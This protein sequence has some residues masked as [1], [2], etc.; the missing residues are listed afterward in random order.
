MKLTARAVAALMLPEGK[1]DAIY[2]DDDMP[3]FGY[4]LRKS[5]D[6]VARSWVTQYRHGGA[7][8]RITLKEILSAE[9]ARGEAKR[10]L[11][12]AALGQDP[13]TEKKRQASADR[14]TFSALVEQYLAAKKPDV[15]PRSFTETQRYLQGPYFKPLHNTPVDS[16]TRRDVSTRVLTITR[17]NGQ[18]AAARARSALSGMYAWG[19]ASGLTEVNPTIG[20]PKPKAAPPRDRVLSDDEL[21]RIWRTAG[22]D[23]FGRIVKLLIATGQRRSEC[24]GMAWTELRDI[25]GPRPTWSIPSQRVKNGRAHSLPLGSLAL[26][27]IRSVPEVLGRDCLFGA[28]AD[29]GFTSW[30]EHKGLLDARLGDQVR[31]WRLHDLRRTFCTRLN[32]IGVEPHIC[33]QILNHQSHRGGTVGA[34]YNRSKYARAVENAMA[35]WDRHL[36]ALIEGRDEQRNVLAFPQ[37]TAS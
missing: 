5:G 26:E 35:A 10:L 27:I 24:G 23:D 18:V 12:L 7:T 6:K 33:E 21:L 4:R 1:T 29:G 31:P 8:R 3:G 25:D 37:V 20:T 9:Q 15:R 19:M 13:A 16:I 17:E 34:T 32:D 11:A 30:A 2:F 28:R 36:R 14:F 22:D